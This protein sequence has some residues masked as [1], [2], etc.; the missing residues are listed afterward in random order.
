MLDSQAMSASLSSS[1]ARRSLAGLIPALA[2]LL[3]SCASTREVHVQMPVIPANLVKPDAPLVYLKPGTDSR[4]SNVIARYDEIWAAG[5]LGYVGPKFH[6]AV[7]SELAEYADTLALGYI[8]MK[9]FRAQRIGAELP[10]TP[11]PCVHLR[12]ISAQGPVPENRDMTAIPA[13][14]TADIEVD[15]TDA[16]GGEIFHDS[17]N[18]IVKG[19]AP[20]VLLPFAKSVVGADQRWLD[21]V[22]QAVEE[23]IKLMV[24]D[25]RFIAAISATPTAGKSLTLQAPNPS[26]AR[27]Q[28]G[29]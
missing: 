5:Q 25:P 2:I 10:S 29:K 22:N 15:V 7:G 27:P 17:Y 11:A 16:A 14:A 26:P 3:I 19:S 24:A 20:T 18:A 12:L 13:G 23:A 9:G 28:A 6:V 1:V 8:Q 4:P 21:L